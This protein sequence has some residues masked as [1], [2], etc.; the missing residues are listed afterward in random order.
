[1][2]KTGEKKTK[3]EKSNE[4]DLSDYLYDRCGPYWYNIL[5]DRIICNLMDRNGFDDFWDCCD[6]DIKGEIMSEI[7]DEICK[8]LQ[9]D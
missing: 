6:D 4:F 1:M 3:S 5:A 7:V 8:I 9:I 2:M